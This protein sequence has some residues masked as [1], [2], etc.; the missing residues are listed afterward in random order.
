MEYRI[1][2]YVRHSV[3][4][5]FFIRFVFAIFLIFISIFP[6]ILPIFPWSIFI[7]IPILVIWL[8]LIVPWEK[9]KYVVKIRKWI[10]YLAKNFHRKETVWQ[11]IRDIKLHIRDILAQK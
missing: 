4:I 10:I 8:M 6:I 5:P 7:G 11:K 3:R 2:R 1:F 9:I